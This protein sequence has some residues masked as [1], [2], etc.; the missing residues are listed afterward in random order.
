[1]QNLDNNVLT[2]IFNFLNDKDKRS[3]AFSFQKALHLYNYLN[4]CIR[5]DDKCFT[6]RKCK[7]NLCVDCIDGF[8]CSW[9]KIFVCRFC[10]KYHGMKT[11]NSCE[12]RFNCCVCQRNIIYSL[13]DSRKCRCWACP[14]CS[15][16]CA[17]SFHRHGC[18][19][20]TRMICYTP[21]L[22]RDSDDSY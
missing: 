14:R 10:E 18:K 3:L 9:C 17:E 2:N 19:P 22:G 15:E 5:C 8:R 4:P 7:H 20:C 1:M 13:H 21:Y 12:K 16:Q 6:I 11:S